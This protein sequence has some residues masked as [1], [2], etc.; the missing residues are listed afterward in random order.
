MRSIPLLEATARRDPA[1][2]ACNTVK[3]T[4]GGVYAGEWKAGKREGR[5]R[6]TE[7]ATGNVYD[8]DWKDGKENGRGKYTVAVTGEVYEGEWEDGK[9]EGIFQITTARGRVGKA[10]Y[11]AGVRVRRTV[12]NRRLFA[13]LSIAIVLLALFLGIGPYGR[14][15]RHTFE[16]GDV[17]D[18]EWKWWMQHGNGTYT[19]ANGD[20]YEG[21]WKGWEE[22]GERHGNGKHVC[23]WRR[24]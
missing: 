21:E 19:W 14:S 16:N 24:V 3:M 8:G 10:E 5:G 7:A 4:D 17:Y 18:G 15:N 23:E 9:R 11:K 6:Q 1:D 13:C 2:S 12:V 22:G 20:V